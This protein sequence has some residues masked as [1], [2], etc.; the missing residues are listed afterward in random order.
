MTLKELYAEK[1]KINKQIQ[2]LE[3]DNAKKEKEKKLK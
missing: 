1:E 3:L 2:E